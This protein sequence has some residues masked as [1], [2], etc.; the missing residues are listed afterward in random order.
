MQSCLTS[1]VILPK[2]LIRGGLT[3]STGCKSDTLPRD[4]LPEYKSTDNIKCKYD[5]LNSLLLLYSEDR[6]AASLFLLIVT[7]FPF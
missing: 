2:L 3:P 1:P 6:Q 4:Y 7:V 5:T